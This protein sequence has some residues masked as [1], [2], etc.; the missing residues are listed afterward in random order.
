MRPKFDAPPIG[1]NFG[2]VSSP[3]PIDVPAFDI[4]LVWYTSFDSDA[5]SM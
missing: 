2:L 4:S 3:L 1:A 5:A